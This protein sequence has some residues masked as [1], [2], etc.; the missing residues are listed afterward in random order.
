MMTRSS[1]DPALGIF[2]SFPL[3]R[4]RIIHQ[5]LASVGVLSGGGTGPPLGTTE[6]CWQEMQ[7]RK[8]FGARRMNIAK[9]QHVFEP[10]LAPSL[11]PTFAFECLGIFEGAKEHVPYWDIREVIGVMT[12]LMMNPMRFRPLENE[13]NPR[14]RFDVPMIEEFSHCDQNGIIPSGAHAGA[15]QWIHNQ[16]AEDGI[17]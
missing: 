7:S 15:K 14:R 13:A 6:A 12:K 1:V 11:I 16:T 8:L 9:E 2:T 4:R 10:I 17:N 3:F 5:H